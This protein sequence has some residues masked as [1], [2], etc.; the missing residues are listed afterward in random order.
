MADELNKE[1]NGLIG[2]LRAKADERDKEIKKLSEATA[3]TKQTLGKMQDDLTEKFQ[4]QLDEM[5]AKLNRPIVGDT[6]AADYDREKKSFA[7]FLRRKGDYQISGNTTG[8]Y[9]V[10]ALMA[11]EI[12][13]KQRD[14]DP[15]RSLARNIT[16]S[17]GSPL[18][19]PR[20]TTVQ[21]G[22][23]TT[24]TASRSISSA[25]VMEQRPITPHPLYTQVKVTYALLEDSAFDI[26]AL[27]SDEAARALAYYEGVSFVSGDGN[28]QPYGVLSDAGVLANAETAGNDVLTSDAIVKVPFK[29]KPYYQN[30]AV[31]MMSPSTM[32][33][34]VALKNG[35][36]GTI[37]EYYFHPAP[38]EA[39]K[40][41]LN[42]FPVYLS[43]TID[44]IGDQKTV[45]V[46]GNFQKGYW[47]ADVAGSMR[48]IVDPYTVK[49]YMLYHFE[50]RV[51]ANVVDPDAFAVIKTS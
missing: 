16:I 43:D 14:Y 50:K 11:D 39:Y 8:G 1:I 10:P 38:N 40:W 34:T 46:F 5:E 37:G 28:G 7:D 36:S 49:G 19:I 22:G 30:G 51:G 18:N 26:A 33:A 9:T 45:A 6:K 32:A 35:T 13:R 44:D 15:V 4:K 3:E 17:N 20:I 31:Y 24:E 47:I 23:F 48:I 27:I 41:T 29:I 12:I 2:E 21:T 25:A 42:G